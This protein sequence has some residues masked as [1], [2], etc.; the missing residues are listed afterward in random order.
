[1]MNGY[2]VNNSIPTVDSSIYFYFL[3]SKPPM[4]AVTNMTLNSK[5]AIIYLS[6]DTLSHLYSE[7]ILFNSIN[8]NNIKRYFI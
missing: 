5:V 6:S 3:K 7:L 2:S 1:M 8:I 4:S